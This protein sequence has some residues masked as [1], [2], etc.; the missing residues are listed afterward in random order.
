MKPEA[1]RIVIKRLDGVSEIVIIPFDNTFY[2]EVILVNGNRGVWFKTSELGVNY[3]TE[4][5]GP[6]LF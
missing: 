3:Y 4:I 2:T 6:S 5:E 1:E